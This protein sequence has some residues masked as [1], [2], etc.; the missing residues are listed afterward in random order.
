MDQ[1]LL[2]RHN[3]GAELP[4]VI[5][6]RVECNT[7]D[8]QILAN[9]LA[10]SRRDLQ[11][12]KRCE[13]HERVAVI[14]GS[15]PSIAYCAG[16][17]WRMRD[18]KAHI[19]ALNN[20]ANWLYKAHEIV[21]D[22]QVIMDAQPRTTELIGPARTHLF[23]SMVDPA[24]FDMVPNPV[25]WHSTHGDLMV[26]EQEGFPQHDDDYCLI[27]SGI[28]VGNTC[29]PLVYAMGYRTIH[30]F[31]MDSSHRGT[32][33]HVMHQPIN[34]G[35]PWLTVKLDGREFVCSFTMKLQAINFIPRARQL[36]AAGCKIHMHG[37][38]YLPTLW[39]STER[40]LTEQEKYRQMWSQSEYS[41]TSPGEQI[42]HRFVQLAQPKPGDVVADLGCGTGRG[43]WAI[44]AMTGCSVLYV[45]FV[46]HCV[47]NANGSFVQADL[48]QPIPLSADIS[49]C[50]DVM[51]HIPPEQVDAVLENVCNVAPR[52]FFQISLIPDDMGELIGQKLHL[53]VHEADWWLQKLEF[54][55]RI[56]H[57]E[58]H[59][60][61]AIFYLET[62]PEE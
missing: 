40:A 38:G 44:K 18:S 16:D 50:C 22:Y 43:G 8:M 24:L 57:W 51:E 52:A 28:T 30:V 33:G 48:T 54:Y 58:D 60:N 2:T 10:N 56:L 23:A 3:P 34:D 12:I 39:R 11:W 42:A 53:S 41:I 47:H 6:A 32:Q 62:L 31:G 4:L 14:C 5:S 49:Y 20:A 37:D 46:D 59:G 25:L 55:G 26:D 13:P 15:G 27:G 17:L 36:E 29:L 1:I 7:S 61:S 9:V 45:D 35:D 19:F 21:P